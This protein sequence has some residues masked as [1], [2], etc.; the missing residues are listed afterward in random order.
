MDATTQLATGAIWKASNKEAMWEAGKEVEA[1][2]KWGAAPLGIFGFVAP[3]FELADAANANYSF[4]L[5]SCIG[6]SQSTCILI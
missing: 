2:D 3:T 4:Q 5:L 1:G 6:K